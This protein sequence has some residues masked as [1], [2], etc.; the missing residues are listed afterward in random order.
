MDTRT[1][2]R[3][4]FESVSQQSGELE[5]EEEN[6]PATPFT[7]SKSIK[8]T[9]HFSKVC[10]AVCAGNSV[11]VLGEAGTGKGDFALALHQE[12]SGEFNSAIAT[13]KGS[14]KKFFI[15][16]AF[17]LDI[18]TTE[19]QYNKNGDPTGEKDLTVDDT[20][21]ESNQEKIQT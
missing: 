17:Q 13:Y 18:P 19:T 14:L 6:T 7:L 4:D 21:G 15:A 3:Q 1:T 12:L 5:L 2:S 11:L 16:I 8:D 10:D 20:V 9:E